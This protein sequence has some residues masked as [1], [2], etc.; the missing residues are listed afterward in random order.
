MKSPDNWPSLVE[1]ADLLKIVLAECRLR[2][3]IPELIQVD[4]KFTLRCDRE[5]LQ[6]VFEH[7]VQNAQEATGKGGHVLVRLLSSYGSALVEIEDDGIG[8]NEHFVQHRLFKPF[9]STKGLTGM[10]IGAFESREFIRSLGGNIDVQST[11]GRG[12]VFR[13]SIP[14]VEESGM[15]HTNR[16]HKGNTQ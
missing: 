5:R 7:L 11:P 14:C 16:Q 2:T 1:L 4:G 13:V 9:D 6:T 12:S 15:G 3:P 8:M 10:G